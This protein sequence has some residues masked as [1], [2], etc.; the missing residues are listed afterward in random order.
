[1]KVDSTSFRIVTPSFSRR[2]FLVSYLDRDEER[3]S[4]FERRLATVDPIKER[5][6]V[7]KRLHL[8]VH[9]R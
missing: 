4:P 9:E 3:N 1:M 8:L 7:G 6:L 5:V 2:P